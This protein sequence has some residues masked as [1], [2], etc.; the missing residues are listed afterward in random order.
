VADALRAGSALPVEHLVALPF[1]PGV[2][3]SDH[4]AFWKMGFR[5]VMVTDTAFYRNPNYHTERDT[6][7]TLRFDRM[8]DL[9]RGMVQV[10]VSLTAPE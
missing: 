3:L 9:V 5:A 6:I 8:S 7:G 10:A 2:S 4:G 1:V